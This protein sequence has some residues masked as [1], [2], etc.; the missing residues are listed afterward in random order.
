MPRGII[1]T[2]R[3][4]IDHIAPDRRRALIVE[5]L[6][7]RPH[8]EADPAEVIIRESGTPVWAIIGYLPAVDGELE[9]VAKDY[10]VDLEAVIAAAA[11]YLDNRELI[12]WR[13]VQNQGEPVTLL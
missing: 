2:L 10:G 12:D 6:G 1:D 4:Q 13:L 11:Y 3:D 5:R 9:Q 8:K 7:P